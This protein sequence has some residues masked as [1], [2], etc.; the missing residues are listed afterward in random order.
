MSRKFL[1]EFPFKIVWERISREI[2]LKNYI[3]LVEIIGISQSVI[4]KRKN[5]NI[6]PVEWAYVLSKK[7]GLSI[8]W[9]LEGKGEKKLSA[10]EPDG[11]ELNFLKEIENWIEQEKKTVPKISDWF[12]VEFE[13]KFPEFAKWKRKSDNERENS[14]AQQQNV[15]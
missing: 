4:S 11:P 12:E 3:Q 9:I 5:E 2:N 1:I 10:K 7:Y 14:L 15:A 6:F 13:K 8:E